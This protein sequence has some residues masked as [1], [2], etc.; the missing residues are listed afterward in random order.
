L[1]H[2]NDELTYKKIAVKCK[3]TTRVST[4]NLFDGQNG[5]GD[6]NR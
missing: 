1:L 3:L 6:H 2:I 4:T 5:L